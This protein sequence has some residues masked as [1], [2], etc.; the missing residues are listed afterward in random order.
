MVL[1]R[2]ALLLQTPVLPRAP[3]L[4]PA[5]DCANLGANL[6]AAS[7]TLPAL[8]AA[9]ALRTPD[10]VAVVFE[11]RRLSYAE[12]DAHANRLAHHLRRLGA[13]PETVVGLCV[14]RSIEM[15]IGLIGILKAGAAYLPLD[16]E[17]PAARL[18]DMVEDAGLRIVLRQEKQSTALRLP[19]GV[20]CVVFGGAAWGIE[21]RRLLMGLLQP[22]F[23][24]VLRVCRQSLSRFSVDAAVVAD[25]VSSG[26]P[27]E[28]LS[29]GAL[30]PDHLAYLIYTSG[31]T[32]KPKG[33][34]NTHAGLCNR[35]LWMQDAYRLGADDVVLQKTPFSFDVSVWEFFWPLIVGA[36]LVLAAP[37]EHREPA[38][39]AATIRRQGVTVLHFVPSML[40][41]FMEHVSSEQSSQQRAS[42]QE[43]LQDRREEGRP[44]A[45]Q[46]ARHQ[47]SGR[48]L[49]L[50][51]IVCSGEALAADLR[52]RVLRDLP[53]VG[54]GEPLRPDRSLD[55]CDVLVLYG[56]S[57]C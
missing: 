29:L 9:Q 23:S 33:A 1:R 11:E 8:F 25:A 44:S 52:D 47:A 50:R 48:S 19:R 46:P 4:R 28:A 21:M 54:T 5:R 57:L 56:R 17:Y 30:R 32:G 27:L 36:R 51:R 31:S 41:A 37:G 38:R 2:Q 14:E 15:V 40:Q 22:Q 10:A 26:P 16:P 13:G 55:R 42:R 43:R 39:L 49:G 24:I 34:G 45:T 12:L 7:L 53:N 18:S 35:L 20:H 6:G 3:E